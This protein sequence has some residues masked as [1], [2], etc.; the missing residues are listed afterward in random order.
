MGSPTHCRCLPM[1]VSARSSIAVMTASGGT[2]ALSRMSLKCLCYPFLPPMFHS[3]RQR[4][5]HTQV[6]MGPSSLGCS[7]SA[8]HPPSHPA[9]PCHPTNQGRCTR[10]GMRGRDG[11]SCWLAQGGVSDLHEA[12]EVGQGQGECERPLVCSSSSS[13]NCSCL[14]GL[15]RVASC[16]FIKLWTRALPFCPH[17]LPHDFKFP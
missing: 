3:H 1:L 13:S 9:S 17:T 11:T 15:A 5:I 10:V 8:T 6:T 12:L 7:C 14:S 2:N 4:G 16:L